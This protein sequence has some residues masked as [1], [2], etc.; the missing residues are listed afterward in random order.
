MKQF[1]SIDPR[2]INQKK[3]HEYL[4]SSVCPRPICFA[5]TVDKKGNVNLSPFSFFNVVSSNPPILIFSPA[6]RGTDNTQKHTL[7]N[8]LEVEEVVIHIIDY[9][10]VEQM[11][12]TST[13]YEKDINEFVK[14][15]LTPLKSSLV[16]PPRVQEAP[17]AFECK[18]KNVIALGDKPGAGN[19]VLAEVLM[20][21]FHK[22]YLDQQG[23]LTLE[24]MEWVAR[25]GG[26]WYAK[27][28]REELFEIPKP[29]S[30]IGIGVDQ[31]PISTQKSRVLSGNNLGR[32]GNKSRK[33]KQSEIDQLKNTKAIK[34]IVATF[35]GEKRIEQLHALAK[36]ELERNNE[37]K[38][39]RLVFLA[40]QL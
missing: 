19:L 12:L 40:E 25:M 5:S 37:G 18:V 7:T 23:N 9:P 16:R 11:S 24:K 13:P 39:L 31:L 33:P 3:Q 21:H 14:A 30:K 29:N 17:I 28:T 4:L 27:I 36:K 10:M 6:R 26:N 34:T 35:H 2:K 22:N 15:G 32:L 1:T 38:A 20:M 8:M